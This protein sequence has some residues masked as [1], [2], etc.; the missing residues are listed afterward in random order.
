MSITRINLHR[1]K[2]ANSIKIQKREAAALMEKQKDESARIKVEN[3]IR[4]DYA[5][6]ALEIIELFVELLL[7]RIQVIV[8][9]KTCP[10]DLKEAITTMCYAATRLEIKEFENIREQFA[11]KF[12]KDFVRNASENKVFFYFFTS[13]RTFLSTRESCSS[14][15]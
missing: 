5:I 8:E 12:G 7:S 9:A 15:V 10:H 1:N 11:F 2:K 14:W 6:E 13:K 4:E 3:I